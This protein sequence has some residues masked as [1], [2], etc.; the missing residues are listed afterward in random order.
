MAEARIAE[1]EKDWPKAE[2]LYRS[3]MA[4]YPDRTA[5]VDALVTTLH[6]A[7]RFDEALKMGDA[8][9]AATEYQA[10]IDLHPRHG[11]VAAALKKIRLQR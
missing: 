7:K 1:H 5:A 10:A 3:L 6:N 4:E 2:R 8:P 11:P 9:A